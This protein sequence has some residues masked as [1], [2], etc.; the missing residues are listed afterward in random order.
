MRF[1]NFIYKKKKEISFSPLPSSV[2]ACRPFLP[3]P[4]HPPLP[5]PAQPSRRSRPSSRAPR[6]RQPS[7]RAQPSRRSRPSSRACACTRQPPTPRAQPLTA[8]AR[9]SAPSSPPRS[10]EPPGLAACHNC[11]T[12]RRGSVPPLAPGR[13]KSA[14][15]RLRPS[16]LPP[17][18]I[19]AFAEHRGSLQPSPRGLRAPSTAPPRG[20][21]PPSRLCL[22][23]PLGEL[24]R[25]PLYLPV[26]L[27][28]RFVG[29]LSLGRKLRGPWS[30]AMAA[31]AL[32]AVPGRQ[33]GMA[34]TP[35]SLRALGCPW[36]SVW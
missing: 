33:N 9:L 34:A 32:A 12:P 1:E 25:P 24:L 13:F 26:H 8:R 14:P 2:S 21:P 4:V 27:T 23:F 30:P 19:F 36:W 6:R 5:F 7:S 20:Q 28:P 15:S 3:R 35:F 16:L 18:L 22:H 10:S 17:A 31:T 29:F 11:P